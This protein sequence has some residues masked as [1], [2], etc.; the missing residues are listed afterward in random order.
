[1]TYSTDLRKKA[2]DYIEKGGSKEEASRIFGV[3][4]RTLLNWIKRKKIGC[5][6]PNKRKERTPHKIE[7]E[8]L[9][10]YLKEHP[11][12][13]LREIA[14]F[15]GAA[16]TTVFYACKRLKITLKKKTPFYQERD[17]KQREEFHKKLEGI[18]EDKRVYVDE[19]GINEYLQRGH[20]RSIRGDKVYGAV[21]GNRYSRESFIA[22]QNQSNVLAPFCYTGTCDTK[23]FNAWLEQILIPQ[24]KPGQV[25]IL[26]NASFH[27]S[28]TSVELLQK[29]GCEVLFLPA[30]SPDLNPIEKFWASFKKHV[31]EVLNLYPTLA[32]AIDQSFLKI[33]I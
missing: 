30:Y 23:L 21:S 26:D 14:Q 17:E 7:N 16:V 15:F 12:A 3:T 27:K 13:Y 11:D 1:M 19:S 33:C 9:K 28:K 24:L 32:E 31:R 6:A 8:K 25:V 18:P 20:A 10:A 22:A 2:L 29:A 5:L 4:T